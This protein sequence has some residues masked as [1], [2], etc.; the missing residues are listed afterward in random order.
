MPV[1]C[2]MAGVQ[3]IERDN[4]STLILNLQTVT[5]RN[6]HD[7]LAQYMYNYC[8]NEFLSW[9]QKRIQYYIEE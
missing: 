6:V 8:G 3:Q 7:K 4:C 5:H 2:S 9:F 1:Q